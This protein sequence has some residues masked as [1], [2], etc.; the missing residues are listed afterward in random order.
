MP[1]FGTASRVGSI[2]FGYVAKQN[3]GQRQGQMSTLTP[4]VAWKQEEN[5]FASYRIRPSVSFRPPDFE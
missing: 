2:T 5:V 4:F 1:G 3:M